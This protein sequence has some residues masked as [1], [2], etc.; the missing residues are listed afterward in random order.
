MDENINYNYDLDYS[1]DKN[2]D[3]RILEVCAIAE[4]KYLETQRNKRFT[5]FPNEDLD[6]NELIINNSNK[7]NINNSINELKKT[8][9]TNNS[10]AQNITYFTGSKLGRIKN[11]SIDLEKNILSQKFFNKNLKN[12]SPIN[13]IQNLNSF[14]ISNNRKIVNNNFNNTKLNDSN[15]FL[16]SQNNFLMNNRNKN[17][18][19]SI[20]KFNELNNILQS[21]NNFFMSNNDKNQKFL[22]PKFINKKINFKSLEKENIDLENFKSIQKTYKP[23]FSESINKKYILS[24]DRHIQNKNKFKLNK[25]LLQAQSFIKNQKYISAYYLLRNTI[26]TGEYH[27]DLFYLYGEVNRIL[28]NYQ[29][30]EDYLL[31]ALNFEIHSPFVFY[32]MGLLYQKLNQYEYSNIFFRLFQR[33]I[34][35]DNI[36]FLIAKNYMLI[37]ELLKAAKEITISIKINKEKDI[38]Y[39]LRSE[40]YNKMGL[41]EM[42]ND[43]LDMYNYIKNLK[44][45]ENK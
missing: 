11:K 2:I 20:T 12:S 26:S 30:A 29:I 41:N 16:K 28:E 17:H 8:L 34:N 31:L 25:I 33:L 18:N 39:K 32:S 23:L 43:D 27:S 7:A 36:H 35:N 9:E 19:L 6:I 1:K 45:E 13:R 15:N 22:T 21:Q 3:K 10:N 5:K 4:A 40:I 37:G 14:S 24:H 44:I 38:Y 42:A